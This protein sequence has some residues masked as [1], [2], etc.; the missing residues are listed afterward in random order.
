MTQGQFL[1]ILMDDFNSH[2][3]ISDNKNMNQKGRLLKDLINRNNLCIYNDNSHTYLHPANSI[4]TPI[5]LTL[6]DIS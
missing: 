4:F 3:I 1:K 2:N 5:D 6:S